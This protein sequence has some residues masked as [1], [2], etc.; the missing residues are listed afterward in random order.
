MPI[1][2]ERPDPPSKVRKQAKK[3]GK[4]DKNELKDNFIRVNYDIFIIFI[5]IIL[6]SNLHN[7]FPNV[8]HGDKW[9]IYLFAQQLLGAS[10]LYTLIYWIQVKRELIFKKS[11]ALAIFLLS[12]Y[13]SIGE[14][15]NVFGID[16]FNQVDK[17]YR[18]LSEFAFVFGVTLTGLLFFYKKKK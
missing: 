2:G 18:L 6:G 15:F 1:G 5:A 17:G 3:E 13:C 10:T 7:F 11:F 9:N 4:I 12:L 14:I 16:L 8:S